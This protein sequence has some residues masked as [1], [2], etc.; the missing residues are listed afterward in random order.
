MENT[1]TNQRRIH[2][3]RITAANLQAIC[4]L[5]QTLTPAQ[6]GMVADNVMSVAE[7]SVATNSWL[8][9][10][11]VDDEPIG[12]IMM[13]YGSDYEDGIDCP[14]AFLWRLMIAGPYQGKGYGKEAMLFLIEHLKAQGYTELYTS[15]GE[16]EASPEPFYNQ[17]GFTRTGGIYGDEVELVLHFS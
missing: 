4:K 6:Q 16:G 8:R 5:S 3:R 13:H 11:Y 10:I 14:G 12:L 2:F 1:P 9:A 7:Y 17:L 15:C